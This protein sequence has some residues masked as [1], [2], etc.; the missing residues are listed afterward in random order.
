MSSLRLITVGLS[1]YPK[2]SAWRVDEAEPCRRQVVKSFTRHGFDVEDWTPR[3]TTEQIGSLWK[4]FLRA[5]DDVSHVIYWIGHG[6]YGESYVAA[7]ADSDARLNSFTGMD[8]D[9]LRKALQ[10]RVRRL[11]AADSDR[12][13]LVVLDTC[14]SQRGAWDVFRGFQD[15]PANFGIVGTGDGAAF[16]GRFTEELETVLDSFGPNETA[17]VRLNVLVERLSARLGWPPR[18]H[19]QFSPTASFPS[20]SEGPTFTAPLDVYAELRQVLADAP[21]AL[22]NHFYARAQGSEIGTPAWH[23]TGRVTERRRITAWLREA[24]RGMYAVTGEPGAGKSALIGMVLASTDESVLAALDAAGHAPLADDLRPTDVPVDAAI[25]LSGLTI[26]EVTAELAHL[27]G[28]TGAHSPDGLVG[29]LARRGPLT[30]VADA[31]DECR[32]PFTVASLLAKIAALPRVRVLVGTRQS[33]HE[34]P[35]DPAPVDQALADALGP[36]TRLHL[37]REPGAVEQYVTDRLLLAGSSLPRERVEAVAR[38]V[39]AHQQPFLFARLAVHEIIAEPGLGHDDD[40]LA[41]VLSR[42]HRGLFAHAFERLQH[43]DERTAALVRCLAYARGGGFPRSGNVWATVTSALSGEDVTDVHVAAALRDA[44]PYVME[45]SEGREAVYRLAHRTFVDFFRVVDS[46]DD[47]R[48]AQRPPTSPASDE[49]RIVA[50]LCSLEPDGAHPTPYVRSHLAEHVSAADDWDRFAVEHPGLLAAL[51]PLTVR[52]EGLRM[53]LGRQAPPPLVAVTMMEADAL[54]A[55][56]GPGRAFLRTICAHQL[57]VEGEGMHDPRV[58]HADLQASTVHVAIEAAGR[59]TSLASGRLEDG[60]AVVAAVTRNPWATIRFWDPLTG[61]PWG[62]VIFPTR[63][64]S[65]EPSD[66]LWW[67]TL[68]GGRPAVTRSK[69]APTLFDA[70]TGDVLAADLGEFTRLRTMVD[71]RLAILSLDAADERA[72]SLVP[73]TTGVRLRVLLS[74]EVVAS[75]DTGE[76]RQADLTSVD[77][78]DVIVVSGRFGVDLVDVAGGRRRRLVPD[79]SAGE[80]EAGVV[81]GRP[82]VAV[83][84]LAGAVVVADPSGIQSAWTVARTGAFIRELRWGAG[85]ELVVSVDDR[86]WFVDPFGS[87]V[88]RIVPAASSIASPIALGHSVERTLAVTA[89]SSKLKLWDHASGLDTRRERSALAQ[90]AAYLVTGHGPQL[91]ETL[92]DERLVLVSAT[93]RR[94]LGHNR[95]LPHPVVARRLRSGRSVVAQGRAVWDA[96]TGELMGELAIDPELATDPSERLAHITDVAEAPGDAV[97]VTSVGPRTEVCAL[98]TRRRTLM[99]PRKRNPAALLEL[100]GTGVLHLQR[101]EC[102]FPREMRCAAEAWR[103]TDEDGL[104]HQPQ[105]VW[106][107]PTGSHIADIVSGTWSGTDVAALLTM[108]ELMLVEG[109]SGEVIASVPE[110]GITRVAFGSGPEGQRLL[111]TAGSRHVGVWVVDQASARRVATYPLARRKVL[112]MLIDGSHLHVAFEDGGIAVDVSTDL[113]AATPRARDEKA[114]LRRHAGWLRERQPDGT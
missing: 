51:D 13:V 14:A 50:G 72:D 40:A 108:A 100:S 96:D 19:A 68:P 26:G 89:D 43:H 38:Q 30:V 11:A 106:S 49:A 87:S 3:A 8:S 39:A 56:D 88:P 31:L 73:R 91:A 74:Q 45:S 63:T 48:S 25:H 83:G 114:Q 69:G 2:V 101:G 6:T 5:S 22:R 18:V 67:V 57:G 82:W 66:R 62:P 1:S 28:A 97:L 54:A 55:L 90:D 16:A 104:T 84:T 15:A 80:V 109:A 86:V 105:L 29:A 36:M 111:A 107:R 35:D 53:L 20:R 76:V 58:V 59:V 24:R 21:A 110:P 32:D 78:R 99:A 44:A 103:V 12:W 79:V 70:T 17:G 113:A 10:E 23:F 71:G 41:D 112:A 52:G 37:E 85:G 94:L 46:G 92:R 93:A 9:M 34:D 95:F 27:L 42:G 61:A 33:L 4:E 77:G 7:L 81:N 102:D 60:R 98:G 64:T 75:F 65:V 47:G